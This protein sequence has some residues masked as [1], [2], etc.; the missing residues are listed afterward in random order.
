MFKIAFNGNDAVERVQATKIRGLGELTHVVFENRVV[1][2]FNDD[3]S[4]I[5]GLCS[6]LYQ[7]IAKRVL[8]NIDNVFFCTDMNFG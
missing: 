4:D 7:D 1:Q 8:K 3:I 6:T 5:N 2:Y